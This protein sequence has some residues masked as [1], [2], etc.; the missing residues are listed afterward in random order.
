MYFSIGILLL[1]YLQSIHKTYCKFYCFSDVK[2]ILTLIKVIF[3]NLQT[4]RLYSLLRSDKS[5]GVIVFTNDRPLFRATYDV[6]LLHPS[7][8]MWLKSVNPSRE[9]NPGTLGCKSSA[10]KP[11]DYFRNEYRILK[12]LR[13]ERIVA[14]LVFS[15]S[16][17]T[18]F[19]KGVVSQIAVIINFQVNFLEVMNLRLK[20]IG[21][22]RFVNFNLNH[23]GCIV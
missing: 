2:K 21:F 10:I 16:I 20:I 5:M 3:I 13:N 9:S 6:L 18:V 15:N 4:I 14:E 1:Y 17:L 11:Q 7:S 19:L 22:L 12:I 8:L 23:N